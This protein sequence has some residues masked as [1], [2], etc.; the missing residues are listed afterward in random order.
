LEWGIGIMKILFSYNELGALRQFQNEINQVRGK[1]VSAIRNTEEAAAAEIT[2]EQ[3]KEIFKNINTNGIKTS[4]GLDG[5]TIELDQELFLDIM[6]VYGDLI[7][8]SV[9]PIIALVQALKGTGGKFIS[10]AAKWSAKR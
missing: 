3:F 9:P 5:I 1:F 8:A 10:L 7:R 2:E 4:F 6:D